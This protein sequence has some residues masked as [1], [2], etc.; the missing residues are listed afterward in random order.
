MTKNTSPQKW[1]RAVR[2]AVAPVAVALSL[3]CRLALNP[4]LHDSS[5][6]MYFFVAIIVSGWLG[7]LGP[8]LAA[9]VL[10][11]LAVDY[12]YLPPIRSLQLE[13][14][15]EVVRSISFLLLGALVSLIAARMR[16]A[17][18][19]AEQAVD[20]LRTSEERLRATFDN[21]ALGI[22]E[23][24]RQ[25]R[26]I[27]VNDRFCQILGYRC[28]EL[29]GMSVH[30]LTAP[31][32]RSR[33]DDLNAQLHDG[34]IKQ[35]DYEKRYLRKDG[36]PVWVHVTVGAVRDVA[37]RYLHSIGTVEDISERK[38]AEAA[39]RESEERFRTMADSLPQIAWVAKPDG[40]IYWY[41]QR[42]YEYTGATPE[43][44]EGWG[45]QSV[46]DPETLPRVLEQWKRSLATGEP[47]EMVF[48]LRGA[49]GRFRR[50]LTR[51][52]PLKDAQGRVVQWFG[53]C[54]DVDELKRAEE[55]LRES[56]QRLSLAQQA[57]RI[58]S[59]EWNIQTDVN[60]WT[61]ELEAMYGLEPGEF[62]GTEQAWEELVHPEDREATLELVQHAFETGQPMEGEWRVRWRDG[63]E[64]WIFGRFQV[65]KDE[66][67]KPLRLTGVNIDRTE[68]KRAEDAL[69]ASEARLRALLTATSDVVYRMSP[70]WREL[71]YLHGQDFVPDTEAPNE[72]WLEKYI[73][74]DDRQHVMAVI[75]EAIRTR[76]VFELEHRV[77]R[78]DGSL[79][80]T[81]S[82]AIPLLDA[83]G[84]VIEWF[85]LASDITERKRAENLVMADLQAMTRLRQT[86]ARSVQPD[87][88]FDAMLGEFVETAIF[89]IGADRGN[90]QLFDAASGALRIKA[91]RGF[92][93]PFLEFF[94]AVGHDEPAVCGSAMRLGERV[95]VEDI[96]QSPIFAG[97]PALAVELEAGVRAVQSTPLVSSAGHLLGMLS[98]H[99]GRPHLFSERDLRLMD[100]LARQAADYIERKQSEE[101]LRVANERLQE[102]DRRKDEFLAMLAH[103]L[104]NP[105]APICYAVQMMNMNRLAQD[106]VV[107]QREL[108]DRQVS[109]MGRLLDDLLEIS[110]ITRGKITLRREIVDLRTIASQA[111][112]SMRPMIEGRGQHLLYEEPI[113]PLLVDGDPTRLEQIIR[114]LLHNA[115]K[116]TEASGCIKL[117]LGLETDHE[118]EW[119]AVVRVSDSGIGIAPEMLPRIFE[120]F[121]QA[122]QGLAHSQG[123][124][125][126]GLGMVK[127]L[128]QMHG[129]SVEAHSAGP[130]QGSEFVVRLPLAAEVMG[131]SMEVSAPAEPSPAAP[132]KPRRV[133]VVDDNEDAAAS[134]GELLSLWGHEV[135]TAHDGRHA[136]AAA[137]QW[138]PEIIL[139]DIGLPGMDGYEVAQRL[140][141]DPVTS[142]TF[143]VA[144]TGYG[145]EEDR[146]RSHE[147]G[148]DRH[149][150]KPVE[151][152]QLQNLLHAA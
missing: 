16:L 49:D 100:L 112:D 6:F 4:V 11:W 124:L 152:E 128:L 50:F 110:R 135:Q 117:S 65:L 126:I 91:H 119:R 96:M 101:S 32:D 148:F 77:L 35:T 13:G 3:A 89:I 127:N 132:S 51:V 44:V 86:G 52:L 25:D 80:W 90:L 114:N 143:L 98:T 133:L 22:G 82:R 125:G 57:A 122:E 42:G 105:L 146:R 23:A 120:T 37:G 63:S 10:S 38:E 147:A 20:E 118:T 70:D 12:F 21:A 7:G 39:L 95:A 53:T 149:L 48:P 62:G 108:I 130:G 76:S 45:W 41:N 97:K 113:S 150:T 26:F 106:Q 123:G 151:L 104:R 121:V 17:Q 136:L 83:S 145:Q 81:F 15:N 36:A 74:P 140:L 14:P 8:G 58:G 73:P 138:Q 107:K 60:T 54:T 92:E 69:Q 64:H 5:P 84:N 56:E 30:E 78:V 43:Q 34:R 103:E 109:H 115:Y 29:L 59:F 85:G 129:G 131:R 144:L 71:R 1:S 139:L 66:A 18:R 102:A 141:E 87:V 111:L 46:H 142:N 40:Y 116:Y 33:S 28:E 55:A 24:D 27:A 79:G 94:D 93:E 19:R 72:A 68:R 67:G 75:N 47:F 61:P 134:L 88:G 99:F 31:E 2:Y 137:R 9:T